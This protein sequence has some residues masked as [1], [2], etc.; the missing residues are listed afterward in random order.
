MAQVIAPDLVII[1]AMGAWGVLAF[2]RGSWR[3]RLFAVLWP[4]AYWGVRLMLGGGPSDGVVDPGEAVLVTGM[5]VSAGLALGAGRLPEIV[6]VLAW[7]VIWVLAQVH[8]PG[9]T[10]TLVAFLLAGS[11]AV[12]RGGNPERFIALA[13]SIGG[14]AARMV[15]SYD[16]SRPQYGM[17]AVD[18]VFLAVLLP[19]AMFSNRKWLLPC[20]A[21][22]LLIIGAHVAMILDPRIRSYAYLTAVMVWF[23]CQMLT[24]V[25]GVF[26]EAERERRRLRAVSGN[27]ATSG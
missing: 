3:E 15:Q 7:P 2:W 25:L 18:L 13:M 6:L 20:A 26:F 5:I 12:W 21:L 27:P 22:Q 17:F 19:L 11:Y 23:W 9:A 16:F 24:L 10:L 8:Q 4:L 1:A 14:A